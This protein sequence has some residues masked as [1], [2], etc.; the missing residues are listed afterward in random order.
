MT[1]ELY[2]VEVQKT[3]SGK[4]RQQETPGALIGRR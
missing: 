2:V 1:N 4:K 3:R